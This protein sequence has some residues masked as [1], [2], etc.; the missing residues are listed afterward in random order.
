VGREAREVYQEL[1]FVQ[2]KKASVEEVKEA[3]PWGN[4]AHKR[5]GPNY[6]EGEEDENEPSSPA[7]G[8]KFKFPCVVLLCD[9]GYKSK[10]SLQ[11]HVCNGHAGVYDPVTRRA[12]RLLWGE[13]Y[14][15]AI[16]KM[17][18]CEPKR[19]SHKT[20][21]RGRRCSISGGGW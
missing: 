12:H 14:T 8:G 13:T 20:K 1:E 19:T 6:K 5:A 16:C 2:R 18:K 21:Q 4:G 10:A 11:R 3:R 17:N 15:I 7:K 9:K